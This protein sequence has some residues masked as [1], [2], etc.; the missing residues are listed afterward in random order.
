[1]RKL[2]LLRRPTRVEDLNFEDLYGDNS[3]DLDLKIER[4]LSRHRKLVEEQ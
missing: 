4:F 3:D 2:K 1:M